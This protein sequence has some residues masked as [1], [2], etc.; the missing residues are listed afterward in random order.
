MNTWV[1]LSR[2]ITD[3]EWYTDSVVLRVFVHLLIIANWQP[4]KWKG[5]MIDVGEAVIG[6]KAL[7]EALELSEQQVRTALDKLE[8]SKTISRRTTNKYTIVKVLKY[9]TYQGLDDEEQPTNNQQITNNQPTNNQQITTPKEVK[10]LR[11]IESKND[12]SSCYDARI[13]KIIK[14]YEQNI[15]VLS[16]VVVDELQDILL[17]HTAELIELAIAEAVK[18]NA[19]NIKYIRGILRN[20]DNAGVKTVAD[21]QLAVAEH[22]RTVAVRKS[23]E[24]PNV[25][26]KN[27]FQDF[28]SDGYEY[29]M[30]QLKKQIG[31]NV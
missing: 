2:K 23:S 4:K 20:W 15:G 10:T 5:E 3:W 29:E 31:E 7:A 16:P 12:I 27:A 19:R 1:K 14:L 30:E 26:K 28:G 17:T 9:C 11:S 8:N 22:N 21:A 24:K 13:K 6:R 18:A 25:V